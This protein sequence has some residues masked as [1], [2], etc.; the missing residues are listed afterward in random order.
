M[1]ASVD[2][3]QEPTNAALAEVPLFMHLLAAGVRSC[4]L[5][6]NLIFFSVFFCVFVQGITRMAP[7][8]QQRTDLRKAIGELYGPG[9]AAAFEA[10]DLD[11]LWQKG[12]RTQV[13]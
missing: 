12:Y 2:A 7:S 1:L 6:S 4:I 13:C 3:D 5:K 10:D 9:V 8:E 11:V